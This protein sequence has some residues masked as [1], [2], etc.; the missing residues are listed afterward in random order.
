MVKKVLGEEVFTGGKALET[1]ILQ[2]RLDFLKSLADQVQLIGDRVH[3]EEAINGLALPAST[4]YTVP[5]N[6]IFFMYSLHYSTINFTATTGVQALLRMDTATESSLFFRS[7][8]KPNDVQNKVFTFAYPLLLK[9][10]EIL[11]FS[12]SSGGSWTARI[13]I[14]GYEVNK[15][16]LF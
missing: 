10:G 5:N 4:F 13:E 14:V 6:R 2:K 12:F 7:I 9:T 11:E 3:L 15:E 1:D 16:I 8:L